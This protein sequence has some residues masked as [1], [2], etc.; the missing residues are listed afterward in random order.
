TDFKYEKTPNIPNQPLDEDN[1]NQLSDKDTQNQ[2]SYEER[3]ILIDVD[4]EHQRSKSSTYGEIRDILLQ[5]DYS[6]YKK[7]L[8]QRKTVKSGDEYELANDDNYYDDMLE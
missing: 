5:S 4:E 1:Q 8:R 3:R 7:A 2:L 6:L